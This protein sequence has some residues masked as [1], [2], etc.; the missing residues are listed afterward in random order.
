ME[1]INI[2][3][4]RYLYIYD[5]VEKSLIISLLN[6]SDD[7]IYWAY[8]LFYSGIKKKDFFKLIWKIYYDFFAIL[9]PTFESYLFK[10]QKE[11]IKNNTKLISSIIQNFLIRPYNIDIFLL[12]QLSEI[13]DFE[14]DFIPID[15]E[16]DKHK[17]YLRYWIINLDYNSISYYI[18]NCL[19][20][21]D[22]SLWIELY[23]LTIDLLNEND[24]NLNKDKLTKDYK[25]SL[26]TNINEKIILLVKILLL[27]AKQKKFIKGKS[28]YVI[29]EPDEVVQYETIHVSSNIRNYRILK[30]S[31]LCGINE[32]GFMNLFKLKRD[33]VSYE[34][35]L[36]NLNNNW[37]YYASF[38]PIWNKRIKRYNGIIDHDRKQIIFED[39]ELE[40][41]FRNKYDYELDEQSQKIKNKIIGNYDNNE[42][43][44]LKFYQ[45]FNKNSLI[46]I[47]IDL[48]EDCKNVKIKY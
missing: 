3:L 30:H 38:M 7:A 20:E 31:L 32:H 45:T 15:N 42:N 6:K 16:T 12:R 8:E 37:L 18:L 28:F 9:N 22:P 19:N 26:R 17:N 34:L 13:Y 40:E 35:L 33:N 27:F 1:N 47:D 46:T 10:K 41:I 23:K 39:E 29:V 11:T 14:P 2:V 24:Y 48:L 43:L 5:E 25:K 4:T 36:N 21:N 44:W